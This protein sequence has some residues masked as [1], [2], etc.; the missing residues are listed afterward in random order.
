MSA[1]EEIRDSAK[2]CV[3]FAHMSLR[4]P[5]CKRFGALFSPRR[6]IEVP[7]RAAKLKLRSKR[8]RERTLVLR[9]QHRSRSSFPRLLGEFRGLKNCFRTQEMGI[10]W[11]SREHQ[12]LPCTRH[13]LFVGSGN[14]FK[15]EEF[16]ENWEGTHEKHDDTT[17]VLYLKSRTSKHACSPFP[18]CCAT[19][20]VGVSVATT[21]Q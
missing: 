9:G 12:T 16:W 18:N 11:V 1:L 10:G 19:E 7:A 20:T 17:A 21:P 5:S 13:K 14:K 15:Y 6:S 8:D 3:F 4:S 2:Q